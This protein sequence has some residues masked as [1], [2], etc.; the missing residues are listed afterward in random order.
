MCQPLASSVTCLV[1]CSFSKIRI[2]QISLPHERALNWTDNP[3]KTW[4]H[5]FTHELSSFNNSNKNLKPSYV[6]NHGNQQH[7]QNHRWVWA[8]LQKRMSYRLSGVQITDSPQVLEIRGPVCGAEVQCR[9]SW[10][11]STAALST[12]AQSGGLP[13][14]SPACSPLLDLITE[15]LHHS[16]RLPVQY[17]SPWPVSPWAS[18]LHQGLMFPLLYA[19]FAF[20]FHRNHPSEVWTWEPHLPICSLNVPVIFEQS[21]TE[22]PMAQSPLFFCASTQSFPYSCRSSRLRHGHRPA[23]STIAPSFAAIGRRGNFSS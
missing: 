20:F 21:L 14:S 17:A 15:N 4:T 10:E 9:P 18:R 23:S 19:S 22:T 13:T 3:F 11:P 5:P 1:L 2:N 16:L 7:Q 8:A 6:S 12:A